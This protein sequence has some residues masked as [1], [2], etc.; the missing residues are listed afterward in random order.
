MSHL[1][2][3]LN[4]SL[5]FG[6]YCY[7]DEKFRSVFLNL[8]FNFWKKSNNNGSIII[9][10]IIKIV[11]YSHILPTGLLLL[12]WID[13]YNSISL[14]FIPIGRWNSRNLTMCHQKCRKMSRGP[15]MSTIILCNV[16]N[17]NSLGLSAMKKKCHLCSVYV[18]R[19]LFIHYILKS[20]WDHGE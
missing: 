7:K 4:S 14:K 20:K 10:W 15:R 17:W 12:C 8:V 1:L 19:T 11:I 3:T 2:L 5:N 13:Y 9:V 18:Q 6:I 16:P